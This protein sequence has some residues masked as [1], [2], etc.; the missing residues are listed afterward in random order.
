MCASITKVVSTTA[1]E[2]GVLRNLACSR[3]RCT[4]SMASDNEFDDTVTLSADNRE[5]FNFDEAVRTHQNMP[6]AC[7]TISQRIKM[8]RGFLPWME[9]RTCR[10]C[11]SVGHLQQTCKEPMYVAPLLLPQ[12]FPSSRLESL[13]LLLPPH[14]FAG[15]GLDSLMLSYRLYL[16]G[17][18]PDND[19]VALPS[20]FI[21]YH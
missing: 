20:F 15:E 12:P 14:T 10:V 16:A 5:R 3:S 13:V 7:W 18:I 21:K 11:K 2:R 19:R 1:S 9:M 8:Q 6:R 17:D 4:T